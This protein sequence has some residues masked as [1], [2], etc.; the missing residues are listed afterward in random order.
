[1]VVA[2]LFLIVRRFQV[3]AEETYSKIR[4]FGSIDRKFDRVIDLKLSN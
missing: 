1:M 3:E 2:E 4:T